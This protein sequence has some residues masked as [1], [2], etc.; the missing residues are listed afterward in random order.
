MLVK[1]LEFDRFLK[2]AVVNLT[3]DLKPEKGMNLPL[4][5]N[6]PE[7]G[8]VGRSPLLRTQCL[9]FLF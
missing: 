5:L 8:T 7:N 1:Y 3:T 4:W 9:P 6:D 2:V